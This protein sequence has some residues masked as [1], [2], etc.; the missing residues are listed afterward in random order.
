MAPAW[1]SVLESTTGAGA[2]MLESATGAGA[3]GAGATGAG[4]AS[5]VAAKTKAEMRVVNC[6]F[7][8]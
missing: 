8:D 4:A 3:T 2:L 1:D 7:S 5:A 6:I